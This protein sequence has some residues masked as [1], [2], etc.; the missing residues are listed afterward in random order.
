MRQFNP[1][2]DLGRNSSPSIRLKEEAQEAARIVEGGGHI[3]LLCCQPIWQQVM[4]FIRPLRSHYLSHWQPVLVMCP[5]FP[6]EEMWDLFADVAFVRGKPDSQADLTQFGAAVAEKIVLLAGAPSSSSEN[7]LADRNAM[8]S[9]SILES[10]FLDKGV[11][12]HTIYEYSY[13]ENS[14]ILPIVPL[15]AKAPNAKPQLSNAESSISS[16]RFA[17]GRIF[18]PSL[19]GSLFA[20]SYTTPG[21]M[22]L[23]EAM[24]MPGRREQVSFPYMLPAL[25][26]IAVSWVGKT[27]G[28]LVERLLTD[29]LGVEINEPGQTPMTATALPLG[30]YRK[31]VEAAEPEGSLQACKVP[32]PLGK[33]NQGMRFVYCN[34]DPGWGEVLL[35]GDQIYVLAPSAWGKKVS[36]RAEAAEFNDDDRDIFENGCALPEGPALFQNSSMMGN[37]TGLFSGSSDASAVPAGMSQMSVQTGSASSPVDTTSWNCM[38]N[39]ANTTPVRA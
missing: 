10:I 8:I 28:E 7:R 29:G 26:R 11:D 20:N 37:L 17:A 24:V 31:V 36:I 30:V 25:E 39:V 19:F 22:E 15:C 9:N 21:I 35:P 34:P 6:P 18:V 4:A 14:Q 38:P 1:D 16:P 5:S 3:L 13:P 23:I 33:A 12:H 27:Y 2:A 32:A